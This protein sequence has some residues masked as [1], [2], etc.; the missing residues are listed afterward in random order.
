M[1]CL[2]INAFQIKYTDS[3]RNGLI[4]AFAAAILI[5]LGELF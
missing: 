3:I 2:I 5:H 1:P 4:L